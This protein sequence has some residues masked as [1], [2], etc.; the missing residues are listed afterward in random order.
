MKKGSM[1]LASVAVILALVVLGA[2]LINIAMRECNSNRDCA[3]NAYCGADHECHYYPEQLV[4]SEAK[5]MPAAVTF[6]GAIILA[7][8][9]FRRNQRPKS[10]F[11]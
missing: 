3:D 11:P 4:I 1:A 9:I 7:A 10:A 8:F 6:G 2:F 5:F